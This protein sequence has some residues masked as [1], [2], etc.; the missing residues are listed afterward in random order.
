MFENPRILDLVILELLLQ[1]EIGEDSRAE[2][3]THG[4][5]RIPFWLVKVLV[6]DPSPILRYSETAKVTKFR[7]LG[8]SVMK[9]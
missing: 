1:I 4:T 7:L 9:P 5:T 6:S 2:N 3:F 8:F